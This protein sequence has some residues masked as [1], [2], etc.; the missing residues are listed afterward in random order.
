MEDNISPTRRPGLIF[1][2]FTAHPQS[3]G[4][5]WA[6]HGAGAV[7]IGFQLIGAGM[8]ALF[9]AAV[10]GCFTETAG[11]TVTRTYNYIQKTRAASS[12]PDNWSDYDI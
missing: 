4:L 8:A 7:K 1:R 6:T 12:K 9:H 2:L 11:R 3:L 10:P 5:S